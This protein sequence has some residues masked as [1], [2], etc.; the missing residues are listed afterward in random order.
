MPE[1]G[2]MKH[3]SPDY[4]RDGKR[5]PIRMASRMD[6]GRMTAH[7]EKIHLEYQRVDRKLTHHGGDFALDIGSNES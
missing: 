7:S 3:R 1:N 5:L 2:A 6:P 4:P